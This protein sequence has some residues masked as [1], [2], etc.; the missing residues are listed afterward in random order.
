[1]TPLERTPPRRMEMARCARRELRCLRSPSAPGALTRRRATGRTWRLAALA[2]TLNGDIAAGELLLDRLH[3]FPTAGEPQPACRIPTRQ[4]Q[5]VLRHRRRLLR[6][7]EL[8][9]HGRCDRG[10]TSRAD[11]LDRFQTLHGIT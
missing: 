9:R 6:C 2:G 8:E 3:D 7:G 11:I 10:R 4:R 5:R 1:M